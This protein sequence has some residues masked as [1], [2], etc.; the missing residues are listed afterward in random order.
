MLVYGDGERQCDPAGLCAAI[1][2]DIEACLAA[3]AGLSRHQRLVSAFII[4]GEL[5]QGLADAR[6][7]ARQADD[8]TTVDAAGTAFLL[9][10]ARAGGLSWDSGFAASPMLPP[11]WRERLF[12]LA[13]PP[14]V[15]IRRPE[16]YA[17]YALYPE[18]YHAAARRSGLGPQ[19][20][21]IG[22]RSIGT[23]LAAM[24]AAALGAAAPITLRPV[25]HPYGRRPEIAPALAER[26]LGDTHADFAIVDEGPGLSG[27]SFGGVADWLV[28]H[29]VPEER[30]H[31][32]PGH[33]GPLGPQARAE[34]RQRWDRR[35]RHVIDFDALVLHAERPD[36]RLEAWLVDLLGPLAAPPEDISGGGWRRLVRALKQA[37]GNGTHARALDRAM[38]ARVER[39]FTW[40]HGPAAG[41][42]ADAPAIS[43]APAPPSALPSAYTA[44]R[45]N[46][47]QL[48][49]LLDS[50]AAAR[51]PPR[52]GG[53]ARTVARLGVK[54]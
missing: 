1:S 54:G 42:A 49:R 33:G 11:D 30:L 45:V 52:A 51:P 39:A 23:G 27:S 20:R 13:E 36:H 8:W 19:T 4:A 38:D 18:A 6:F 12:A 5:V 25:G 32:F 3:P 14:L 48:A 21:V 40:R 28:D 31:F 26:V 43:P 7:A 41:D 53:R 29:G 47:A 46:R 16:G 35:P 50:W 2:A 10:L 22:I 37:A 15:T 34:H 9:E 17:F 24:V 44:P